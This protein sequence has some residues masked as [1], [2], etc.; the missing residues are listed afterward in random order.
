MY[1]LKRFFALGLSLILCWTSF[2][3]PVALYA[4]DTP[5]IQEYPTQSISQEDSR[6]DV[7]SASI[8]EGDQN[9]ID[10]AD[11]STGAEDGDTLEVDEATSA[12][13]EIADDSSLEEDVSS[14]LPENA[15][16]EA[17]DAWSL[18]SSWRYQHGVLV[19]TRDLCHCIQ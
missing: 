17:V 7:D 5:G 14:A 2:M 10:S 19:V 6:E 3:G 8:S 18:A 9:E 12:N 4:D 16:S 15:E 13:D 1:R 11:T